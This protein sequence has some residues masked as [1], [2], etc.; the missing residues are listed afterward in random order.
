MEVFGLLREPLDITDP[1]GLTRPRNGSPRRAPD[2]ARNGSRNPLRKTSQNGVPGGLSGARSGPTDLERASAEE[3][4]RWT[5]ERWHPRAAVVTA[6]QAEGMVILDLAWRIRADV[7]VFTLDTGRLPAESY[8]L[9]EKVRERYG[10]EVEVFSPDARRLEEMVRR[11][12]PNLFYRSLEARQECCRVRKVEVLDRALA[13]L[14]AWLTGLRRDQM[15][16]RAGTRKVERDEAHGGIVK[17]SPLADWTHEK[18]WDY[19][20]DHDV[21]YHA[22]Y[23][24]GYTSIGCAPCT[25]APRA[26]EDARAGRW[27]WESDEPK[28]CGIHFTPG[29]NGS[30]SRLVRLGEGG[31]GR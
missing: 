13:G 4:V 12:G 25:R 30:G 16:S 9:I 23:D 19:I 2:E 15:P 26:E 10:I 5:L 29:S 20:R 6:F 11:S 7:R 1:S 8:E 27:W 24:R 21:P 14:D 22:L 28:E 31:V 3:V 17:V 18:V